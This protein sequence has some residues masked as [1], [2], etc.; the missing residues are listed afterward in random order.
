LLTAGLVKIGQTGVLIAEL[1]MRQWREQ[2]IQGVQGSSVLF[3]T[4]KKNCANRGI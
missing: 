1:L 4:W 2:Q 3:L